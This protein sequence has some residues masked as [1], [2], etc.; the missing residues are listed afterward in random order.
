MKRPFIVLDWLKM[1]AL[2][3]LE[4]KDARFSAKLFFLFHFVNLFVP[5]QKWP[6]LLLATFVYHLGKLGRER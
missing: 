4:W 2:Q 3:V 6:A 1:Y 5:V